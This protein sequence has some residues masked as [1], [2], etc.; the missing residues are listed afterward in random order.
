MKQATDGVSDTEEKLKVGEELLGRDVRI[1]FFLE[2]PAARFLLSFEVDAENLIFCRLRGHWLGCRI[3]AQR[4]AIGTERAIPRRNFGSRSRFCAESWVA[5]RE[6]GGP[7]RADP[8]LG[9]HGQGAQIG[10][11][12]GEGLSL[13]GGIKG[14]RV[15][16]NE[17]ETAE[18]AMPVA[19]FIRF[20][21]I[22]ALEV[23]GQAEPDFEVQV[24]AFEGDSVTGRISHFSKCLGDR[25][26]RTDF[27]AGFD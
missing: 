24:R 6:V 27:Q 4:Y 17:V 13:V 19:G 16:P 11:G 12:C 3:N 14:D 23:T 10:Q 7:G 18:V 1:S 25:Y 22:P 9:R 21:V 15:D 26:G 5:A 2:K 8:Y 20:L